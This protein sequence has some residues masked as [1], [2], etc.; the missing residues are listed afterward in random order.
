M[1][2]N[3]KLTQNIK[4][5]KQIIH[6]E[7]S[8][9][10]VLYGNSTVKKALDDLK[11]GSSGS[12]SGG[13]ERFDRTDKTSTTVGGLPAGSS[14][15]DKT[16]KEVLESI[17]FPYQKPGV[18]FSINPSTSVYEVG[19]SIPSITF[20]INAT[21][22]SNNIVNI[23]VYVGGTL[24]TTI[25]DKVANGGTF[26]YTYNTAINTNT[27]FKVEVSDGTNTVSATKSVT[28]TNKSYFGFI[29]DGVTVTDAVV[30][31]LQNNNLKTTKALSYNSITATNSKIVYAYPKSFGALSSI[32]DGSGFEYI[33]SYTRTEVTIDGVDY[34]VY[35]LTDPVTVNGFL[36]TYA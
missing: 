2:V 27:T 28:F 11:N 36:Q 6:P 14:V 31:A 26:S 5:K 19:N 30:K 9:E 33:S 24:V 10:Q 4:G 3:A 20:S 32:L 8:A 23:K 7:T 17:L 35:T 15:K 1:A 22:H 29:A 12:G 21:K 16:T 18:S 13:S 34:Y 25:T